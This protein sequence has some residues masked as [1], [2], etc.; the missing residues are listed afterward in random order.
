MKD[1]LIVE[2]G[3]PERER[4][5]KL[6]GEAGYTVVG[7]ATVSDA[8]RVLQ[9]EQFRLAVLDI[10]LSDRSGSYLFNA[11][12]RGGKVSQI[13]IYTGN[14][15]V[16]LKQRF[17]DEGAVDYVVKGSAAAQGEMFLQRV[18]ELIGATGSNSVTGIPFE[19]FL[20]HYLSEKSGKLFLEGD[21]SVP[22]C[23]ACGGDKY[24]VT[25]AHKTQVPPEVHGLVVC[26]TCGRPLDPEVG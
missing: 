18:R 24:I 22:N 6:F 9:Y 19:D 23:E 12:K 16:H 4:L 10:G 8:E 11:I 5:E 1:I 13:L 14:P 17:L 7:C 15:S 25:F 2:D 26:A 20:T 3:H 21:S